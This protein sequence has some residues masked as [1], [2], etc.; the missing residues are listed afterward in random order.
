MKTPL[1]SA[2]I[3]TH[4]RARTVGGAIESLLAQDVEAG[5]C[6]ILVVDNRSTDETRSI[7]ASYGAGVRYIAEDTLGLAHARNAG[8]RNAAGRYVALLDD[9][10]VASPEWARTILE[11]FETVRP[12]PGCL[13]GRVHGIWEAPRPRW[14]ADELLGVL[15]VVDWSDRPH[16]IEDLDREWLV[17]TNIAIPRAVLDAIGGFVP[18]LD[19]V[20]TRLLSSGDV[21]LQRQIR[22]AGHTVWYEP[23]VAVGHH[24]P[25]ARLNRRWY[26]RRY[27]AQGLSDTLMRL[28]E[29][30]LRGPARARAAVREA[31][32][33]LRSRRDLA[34]LLSRSDDPVRFTAHCWALIRCGHVAGLFGAA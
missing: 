26:R 28:I 25:A 11:T 4:N 14:L 13:G 24:I 9:D 31:V 7:V 30:D 12:Q 29:E 3:C 16:A 34:A 22:A 15:T 32:A 8:W 18:G 21:F 27:F 23:R 10:A 17:G 20:G 5:T 1:L 33:L 6:E 2:I 19:R